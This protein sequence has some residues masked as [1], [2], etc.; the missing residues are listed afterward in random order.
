VFVCLLRH[1]IVLRQ[2]RRWL[3]YVVKGF[4]SPPV[5]TSAPSEVLL[6]VYLRTKIKI[7]L[8]RCHISRLKCT[9]IDFF[10][11]S[12]PH[13]LRV[14]SDFRLRKSAPVFDPV[15]TQPKG[16]KGGPRKGEESEGKRIE[17]RR[18]D[19]AAT[20][21]RRMKIFHTATHRHE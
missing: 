9:K 6:A 17:G 8:T 15:C 3:G 12:D 14:D 1:A 13:V 16:G 21:L 19:L 11:G 5:F 2:W 20:V 18:R 7:A 10:W 4:I